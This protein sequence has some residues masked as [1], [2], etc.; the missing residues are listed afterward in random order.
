MQNET[1]DLVIPAAYS[2]FDPTNL[3]AN[4]LGTIGRDSPFQFAFTLDTG[5][6][7]VVVGQQ[8]RG[9]GA[10]QGDGVGCTFGVTIEFD[11]TCGA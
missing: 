8:T 7:F 5:A 2:V 9:I 6:D 10:R 1:D 4:F 11:E 3:G